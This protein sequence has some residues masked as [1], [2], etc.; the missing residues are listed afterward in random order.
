MRQ[1]YD[2]IDDWA[3]NLSRSESAVLAGVLS[4]LGYSVLATLLMVEPPPP[5][6]GGISLGIIVMIT[7]YLFTFRHK[8]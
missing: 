6:P 7:T 5:I 4:A 1:I 2:H 8:E 3:D